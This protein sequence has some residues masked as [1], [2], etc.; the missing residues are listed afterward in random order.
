MTSD[1]S[2][3]A[4]PK[5][6]KLF[7]KDGAHPPLHGKTGAYSYLQHYRKMVSCSNTTKCEKQ[8]NENVLQHFV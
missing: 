5:W 3:A 6:S 1:N 4:F 8:V 7:Y 2:P